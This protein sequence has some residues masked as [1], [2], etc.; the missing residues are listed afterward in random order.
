MF[1]SVTKTK[2]KEKLNKNKIQQQKNNICLSIFKIRYE[3]L[4]NIPASSF[5]S[6]AH[7]KRKRKILQFVWKGKHKK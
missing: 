1:I 2:R 6:F 5:H 4:I 7:K 3:N